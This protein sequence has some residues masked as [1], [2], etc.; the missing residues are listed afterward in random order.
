MLS[1][2]KDVTLHLDEFGRQGLERFTRRRS[3]SAAAAVTT[4]SLYYL[5]D[6]ESGRPGWRIPP[7]GEGIAAEA[8]SLSV[9]LDD[10][11]W[12]ALAEEAER[13][14]VTTEALA[15]HALLYFLA[16]LDSGRLADLLEETLEE[17]E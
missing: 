13:Q 9:T 15:R 7:F 17:S 4:A 8:S 14:V 16:D 11:T 6:R 3:G 2:S 5:A 10:A 12:A 1:M